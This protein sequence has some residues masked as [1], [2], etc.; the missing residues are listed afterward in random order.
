[1]LRFMSTFFT[2]FY[3]IF[4]RILQIFLNNNCL[5]EPNIFYEIKL[6]SKTNKDRNSV[7]VLADNKVHWHV[8]LPFSTLLILESPKRAVLL[9][10][11]FDVQ[12]VIMA[13]YLGT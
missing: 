10:R 5:I 13:E 3:R 6:I 7:N 12:T 8:F 11:L 4:L 9:T 2:D 1:M